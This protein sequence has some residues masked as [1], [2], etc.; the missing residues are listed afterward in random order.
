MNL[1]LLFP[2]DFQSDTCATLE[3]RRFRHVLDVH[4]AEVGAQ[5]R[6]GRMD[7]KVGVGRVLS[8]S[9]RSLELEV[10]LD[11]QPPRPLPVTLI[12]GLP[13]P[14][15]LKR[16]LQT[17]SAMGVKD[18]YLINSYRVEKSF[19]QTPVLSPEGIHE[20]LVL[21]LEQAV[22]TSMPKVHLRKLFKPFVEDELPGI[23][24]GTR[25]IVAHPYQAA[26]L[27]SASHEATTLA[28]G[29]EGGFID[30]EV[31]KLQES[32]LQSAH[33]GPRILRVENVVPVLLA[34]LFPVI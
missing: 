32:G 15:M 27:P 29:P 14:R 12:L 9:E 3:G 10:T 1:I 5:L 34:R 30:Y 2:E 25:G 22:D 7:G 19:W 28:V 8:I 17:I 24:A 13:R 21:G 11:E 26:K 18:L 20:H 4:K 16:T 31:A 33:L 23:A 6:V